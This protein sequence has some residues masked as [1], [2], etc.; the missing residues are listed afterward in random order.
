VKKPVFLMAITIIII[1]AGS[2]VYIKMTDDT[3][4]G[5]SIIP[6][7]EKD[8]PLFKGLEPTRANYVS[9]GNHLNEVYEF[10]VNKLPDLGWKSEF[11]ESKFDDKYPGFYS[12]WTKQ[13]FEGELT[14]FGSYNKFEK[15][16]EVSFDQQK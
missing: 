6:E 8:I 10:Y 3:Y 14:I 11:I 2:L 7:Q 5:M 1:F 4:Q 12:R 16:T 15:Q 9:D 13:G